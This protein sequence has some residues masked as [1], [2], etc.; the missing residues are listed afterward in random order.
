MG[1]TVAHC[2]SMAAYNCAKAGVISLSET[3]H[4][5]LQGRGVGDTTITPGFIESR[6]LA[7]STFDN[8]LMRTVAAKLLQTLGFTAT[9]VVEET[10]RGV[11]RKPPVRD[12]RPQGTA[13][14]ATQAPDT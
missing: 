14:V 11:A 9:D 1:R 5:E 12:D 3:L 10:L 4:A 8:E 2:A 7:S 6:L 13:V